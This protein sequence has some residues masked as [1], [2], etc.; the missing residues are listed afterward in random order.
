MPALEYDAIIIGSGP[1]GLTAG[2]LLSRAGHRTLLLERDVHGGALQHVD[3]I[4]DYPPYAGGISGADLASVLIDAASANGLLLEQ[5]DA[6]G[7]EVFSRSRWVAT[8]QG[9]G[10]SCGVVIVAGGARF[11]SLGLPS[12]DRLRGRGL[13]DC[14]PCDAGFYANKRVI[15]VGSDDY[16]LRDALHLA[17]EGAL[18]T[19]LAPANQLEAGP[20]WLASALEAE[21]IDLCYGACVESIVGHDRVEGVVYTAAGRQQQLAA[22]GV[23]IRLGTE[24]NT[25]WL[26]YLLELDADKRVPVNVEL[27]TEAQF[28]LAAGDIRSGS[29]L[30][31]AGAVADG[32]SVAATAMELLGRLAAG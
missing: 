2:S 32:Q 1:A 31:V 30:G 10:F 28:V 20:R 18:V 23:A 6:A 22:A 13:I 5:A 17:G 14:T 21:H 15:V 29:R 8:T 11:R 7:V 4:D 27:E 3:R 16:A 26:T 9:R 25:E 12:E 24:P 19:L